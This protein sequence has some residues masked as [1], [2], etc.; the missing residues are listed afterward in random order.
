[1]RRATYPELSAGGTGGILY[2]AFALCILLSV[3]YST[4]RLRMLVADAR[5][6]TG[7]GSERR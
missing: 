2:G 3:I 1:M 6:A 4:V 7:R 5:A